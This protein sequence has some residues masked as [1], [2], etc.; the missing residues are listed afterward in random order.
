MPGPNSLNP[1]TVPSNAANYPM[2]GPLP[3]AAPQ[4]MSMPLPQPMNNHGDP[5][6]KTE[7]GL[8][9][10][11]MG[12]MNQPSFQPPN[13]NI[14]G[15]ERALQRA[16]AKLTQSYGQRA[17]ASINAIHSNINPQ[18]QQATPQQ[19]HAHQMYQQQMQQQQ[20]QQQN[21]QARAGGMQSQPQHRVQMTQEEYQKKMAMNAMQQQ[22]RAR[23]QGG[24]NGAQTD[25]AGDV[26]DGPAVVIKR[27]NANGQEELGRL[28]IDNLIR[29][30][31]AAKGQAME[32]G[33]LM[34]P[35]RQ[36]TDAKKRQRKV[37]K[38]TSGMPQTDGV[39]SDDDD[40]KDGVKDEAD[41]DED[42]INSDLDDPEDGL[43]DE[44]D[45]EEG[46]GHIM[47]CMYDKVQRVK[48]KW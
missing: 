46:I 41:V 32:G 26:F 9:S 8:D 37:V 40:T 48:N 22:Q 4:P 35:L 45:D 42:A 29:D 30:K 23:A 24:V 16:T 14:N 6:I 36:A 7:P 47:L 3:H 34:L 18:A 31:I 17:D 39:G 27:V 20:Q 25:G 38:T 12:G 19:I 2:S 5:R 13:P 1:P 10:S 44:E 43:D 15:P 28:E 33:G 11:V 21:M